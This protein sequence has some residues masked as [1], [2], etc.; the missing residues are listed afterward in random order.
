MTFLS[1]SQNLMLIAVFFASGSM[2]IWPFIRQRTSPM[3]PLST[4]GTTRLINGANPVLL[5]LR[6]TNEYEGG[7]LPNALHIPLSQLNGRIGELTRFKGRPLVAY[8]A[9]GQRTRAAAG[10]LAGAGFS[11]LYELSGGIRAWKDAGLPIE[12]GT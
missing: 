8:C 5:D 7:R 4:L 9:R 1:D 12:S 2:L 3:K 11:D 10:M 6:E